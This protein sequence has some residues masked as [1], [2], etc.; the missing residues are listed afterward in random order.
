MRDMNDRRNGAVDISEESGTGE[1]GEVEDYSHWDFRSCLQYFGLDLF[2]PPDD[3][4][5]R[6]VL[7]RRI[8]RRS[9]GFYV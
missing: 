2:T 5:D 8:G 9:V 1:G 7:L 3:Q 6:A 4:D